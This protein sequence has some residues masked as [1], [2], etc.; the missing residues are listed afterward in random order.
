MRCQALSNPSAAYRYSQRHLK[1][2]IDSYSHEWDLFKHKP[3]STPA[4]DGQVKQN[5]S[6]KTGQQMMSKVGFSFP[7]KGT[8][9]FSRTTTGEDSTSDESIRF[10]SRIIQQEDQGVFW[11]TFHVDDEHAKELGIELGEDHLPS[12][13][14]SVLQASA[15]TPN[16]SLDRMSVEIASFW[17]L[18]GKGNGKWIS[19]SQQDPPPTWYSNICQ[20]VSID[21]PPG[22]AK[23]AAELHVQPDTPTQQI[24]IPLPPS[25]ITPEMAVMTNGGEGQEEEKRLYTRHRILPDR[26]NS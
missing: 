23:H 9:E 19:Y 2:L 22:D 26:A 5:K 17:S 4:S 13:E 7:F 18:L 25:S 14:M 3:K 20:V 8:A 21:L 12:A 15:G 6:E 24:S 16:Q 1:I 11:W 10:K